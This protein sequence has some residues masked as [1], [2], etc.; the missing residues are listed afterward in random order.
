MQ[1][2]PLIT[3]DDHDVGVSSGATGTEN[4][5]YRTLANLEMMD[6]AVLVHFDHVDGMGLS[7]GTERLYHLLL[8]H[9][10]V[11]SSAYLGGWAVSPWN[12]MD[13]AARTGGPFGTNPDTDNVPFQ[14]NFQLAAHAA[15][16]EQ[17]GHPGHG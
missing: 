17:C 14:N 10:C 3:Y 15:G 4:G 12:K 7:G 6:H 16:L 2:Y 8:F 13:T 9:E 5:L 1:G 11:L